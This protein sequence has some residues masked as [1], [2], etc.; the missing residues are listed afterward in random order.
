MWKKAL[1]RLKAWLGWKAGERGG[2]VALPANLAG[3]AVFEDVQRGCLS[4]GRR[5]RLRRPPARP[6][7][8]AAWLTDCDSAAPTPAHS[9]ATDSAFSLHAYGFPP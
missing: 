1:A 3:L 2:G 6:P 9:F 7:L 8:P 4:P 5:H